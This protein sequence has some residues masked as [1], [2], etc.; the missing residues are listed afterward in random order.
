MTTLLFDVTVV[1]GCCIWVGSV[2]CSIPMSLMIILDQV[3][4]KQA[5]KTLKVQTSKVLHQPNATTGGYRS[6][7][8]VI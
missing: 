3:I 2:A 1:I 5:Q 7:L 4:A 6:K 8:N